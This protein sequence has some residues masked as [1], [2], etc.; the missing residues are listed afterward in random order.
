[1][2]EAVR[3]VDAIARLVEQ[4]NAL[5]QLV[6][7][8]AFRV[9]E[10]EDR[11]AASELRIKP[12]LDAGIAAA[13]SDP[14]EL[15]LNDTEEPSPG[16]SRCSVAPSTGPRTGRWRIRIRSSMKASSRSWMNWRPEVRPQPR[17]CCSQLSGMSPL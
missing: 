2:V 6:E 4:L 14:T 12:L 17:Q 8:L 1:M 16:W 3:P 15:R 7:S 11:L 5:S 13:H 9:V 10:L